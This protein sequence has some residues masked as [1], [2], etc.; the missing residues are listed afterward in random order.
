MP[1]HVEIPFSFDIEKFLLDF[2]FPNFT[3]SLLNPDNGHEIYSRLENIP[4]IG[5]TTQETPE[6]K[7]GQLGFLPEDRPFVHANIEEGDL[8][9][10][11]PEAILFLIVDPRQLP[12]AIKKAWVIQVE[13]EENQEKYIEVA[14]AL[15]KEFKTDIFVTS[16]TKK[17]EPVKNKTDSASFTPIS[18]IRSE[19][20]VKAPRKKSPRKAK[21]K[22][23]TV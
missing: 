17:Y 1:V 6:R 10:F 22:P 15:S 14:E 8:P 2:H 23:K 16:S 9:H 12:P 20:T 4:E 11:E 13:K 18:I 3:L 19:P 21:P 5:M 7:K